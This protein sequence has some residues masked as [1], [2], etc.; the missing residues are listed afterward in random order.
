MSTEKR[1][2]T[3][4]GVRQHRAFKSK[5]P[6]RPVGEVSRSGMFSA[7]RRGA[8]STAITGMSLVGI[9]TDGRKTST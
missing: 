5:E 7:E 3:F 6:L 2:P 8:F 1:F 4:S 9:T